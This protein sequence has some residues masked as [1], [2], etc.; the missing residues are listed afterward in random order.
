[1]K[2]SSKLTLFSIAI[3]TAAIIL[4]CAILLI[5]TAGNH[6]N[7][8]VSSGIAELKM[9]SNSFHAEMDVVVSD[10]NMSETAKS[11]LTLYVFRKYT[12]VS[13]SGAHY[14]LSDGEETMYNDCPIDPRPSLPDLKAHLEEADNSRASNE[15]S[16]LW[17]SAVVALD[18]RKYLV[19]G[20]YS[21]MLRDRIYYEHD[22]YLVRDIT[23]VYEGITKL[24]VWFALIASGTIL[25]CGLTMVILV[26][27]TLLPL[28]EL[29][30]NA[31]ALANGQ[32]DNRIQVLGKDEITE[33][34]AGFNKMADAISLHIETLDDTLTQRK[35]LLSALTHELKTPMTVIIG[36]SEALMKVSLSKEQKE[37]SIAYINRECRRIER[38]SQKMIQLIT[39]QDGEQPEIERQPVSKLYDAVKETLMTAAQ[40]ENII[41]AFDDAGNL[42]FDMDIDMMASVL[43]NLFDNARKAEAKHISITADHTG[44]M[45]KDDGKGIPES[46][47]KKITQPFYMVDK[48]YSQSVGGSGLGLAIC[49]LIL[50]AHDAHFHIESRQGTGTTVRI[51][52]EKLHFDDTLLNT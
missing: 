13:V 34:G 48:S 26:R 49:E 10:D 27:R 7:S 37:D 20:H 17:P 21:N 41:L 30:K 15:E 23:V 32:Y 40:K 52:F 6:I 51:F 35:L 46:E 28:G 25:V 1:M 38:L 29:R 16:V 47:I 24:G 18:G 44:I 22:I 2:I 19:V 31:A 3:T 8:A 14:I 39:L 9:L 42:S 11:S 12:S 43:I 4:C 50:V 33:L 36:Y 5:T 45:V